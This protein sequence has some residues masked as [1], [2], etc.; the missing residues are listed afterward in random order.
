M[1]LIENPVYFIYGPFD[2]A[3][4]FGLDLLKALARFVKAL[5]QGL[6]LVKKFLFDARSSNGYRKGTSRRLPRQASTESR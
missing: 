2:C 3:C 4:Q 6:N 5:G 1:D